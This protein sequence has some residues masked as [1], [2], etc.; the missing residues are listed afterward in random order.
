MDFKN[1]IFNILSKL[2]PKRSSFQK[3]NKIFFSNQFTDCT[4]ND[5]KTINMPYRLMRF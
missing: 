5:T 2:S 3:K 4:H 1:L